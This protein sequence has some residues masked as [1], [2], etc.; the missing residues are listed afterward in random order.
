MRKVTFI[1]LIL[2]IKLFLTV[3][4]R[5]CFILKI[6]AV[7]KKLEKLL[8][9][10]VIFIQKHVKSIVNGFILFYTVSKSDFTY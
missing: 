8:T 3:S 7:F 5:M 1:S 9:E 2:H 6:L 4:Y 10:I